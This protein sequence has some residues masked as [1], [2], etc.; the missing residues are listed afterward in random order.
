MDDH[1]AE[2]LTTT[3]AEISALLEVTF[4]PSVLFKPRI[5]M[6]GDRW[7]A[8]LGENVQT[9]VCGFGE[10]PAL[11]CES[12]DIAWYTCTDTTCGR[13]YYCP[14]CHKAAKVEEALQDG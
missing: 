13:Q 12:F 11:A 3:L 14:K 10:S 8:L 7:C 5:F 1:M 4:K 9:G 6:D 2:R